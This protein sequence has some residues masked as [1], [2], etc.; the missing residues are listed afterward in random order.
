MASVNN[1]LRQHFSRIRS[2]SSGI[3]V[4]KDECTFSFDT[5]ESK[6]GLYIC[7][8]TF[9]GLGKRYVE[10][11]HRKTGNSVFLH[12]RRIKRKAPEESE[13]PSKK[14][15][16][17][18]AIGTEDG[19]SED[20]KDVEV[21]EKMSLVVLPDWDVI[22]LPNPDLPEIVQLSVAAILSADDA[23]KQQE[24]AALQGT[25][26]GEMRAVSK[27][28]ENLVQLDNG[29][30]IPP[31]GWKCDKCD[32]TANLWLN[33]TDGAILCGRRFFDGS[34]GNHHAVDYYQEKKF[35]LAV[36]LGTITPEGAD[37]FSYDEDD[38]VIDPKLSEH[39]SHWGINI[40]N[41]TKTEKTMIEL[42]IDLNQK[43]EYDTIQESG[44]QL[45]PKYGPGFTGIHNLGNSC[46]M[47]SV[48][49]VL[50]TIPDFQKKFF[51]PAETIFQESSNTDPT[52]DFSV[53]MAKLA[54]GLLSGDYS[55]PDIPTDN[56][57]IYTSGIKPWMFRSLIGKGHV[58]FATKRQQD[59]QEFLLHVVN[60]IER[61]TRNGL[62]PCEALK[63]KVEERVE[64]NSSKKVKYSYRSDYLLPLP[65]PK[66]AAI[67]IAEVKEYEDKKSAI[68][69]I[70]AK[71]NAT[72]LPLVR[73]KIP[74]EACL[75]SFAAVETV[76][77]F[78]SSA[79]RARTSASKSTRLASFPDFLIIQLKKFT[80][81]SDWVPQ[82]LDVAVVMPEKIDLTAIRG[83]GI[84]P[85][86][87]ELPEAAPAEAAAPAA[88][89][90]PV[91][92]EGLVMQ[93]VEM[94]FDINGCKK[95][96][97]NTQNMG[98]EAAMNWVMEH[99]GDEDFA[100]PPVLPSGEAPVQP[101]NEEHL[102][103]IISM[104]FTMDQ[105]KK[106]LKATSN[107]IERAMDWIFSHADELDAPPPA[108]AADEAAPAARSQDGA[109]CRDGEGVYE[110]AAIIS[111]MGSSTMVGHYVA[112]IK[113]EGQWY[114]YNDEKVALSENPPMELG[115]LY[116]YRRRGLAPS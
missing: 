52:E 107:N 28:A 114:I 73:P 64:C 100:T 115:Y 68:E 76:D 40:T 70:G 45:T 102:A 101:V 103:M 42:E 32:L 66:E 9:L 39:L 43:M 47:N 77:D 4:H 10:R 94:G 56:G 69:A 50:F 105:A 71:V 35:P 19:F 29:R 31:T 21:E 49:Q 116:L 36:K 88:P 75:Q 5:P 58:E 60:S 16:T 79:T 110:M 85:G 91:I 30:K 74:F 53:Q 97:M 111:H 15:P 112:H 95:A 99:M 82:K 34:G 3:K 84:Q 13:P 38:M 83:S 62:N 55:F 23:W 17:R 108:A 51:L 54:L 59:A 80:I 41:M 11:Y 86:E 96:V 106:A 89:A 113:R 61:N 33:L 87:E 14:T 81:G 22:D 63:F 46:Y 8:N 24:A 65:I 37:V 27:H 12:Y 18:L 26:D 90:L 104:G 25:W 44:S 2:P 72:E 1:V 20:A 78:L 48:M 57:V 93:L 92:D 109:T 67:N 6:D 7:L 98:I